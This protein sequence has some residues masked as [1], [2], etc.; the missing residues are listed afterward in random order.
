MQ[1]S[2]PICIAH[3]GASAYFPENTLLSMKKAKEMGALWVEFDVNLTKDNIPVVFHDET[4]ERI[5]HVNQRISD[6]TRD[7]IKD[8]D[9]GSWFNPLY[10]S[11]RIPTLKEVLQ[12]AKLNK[13]HVNIELKPS[14]GREYETVRQTLKVLKETAIN[15]SSEAIFSSFSMKTL[16]I[17]RQYCKDCNIALLFHEWH[18]EWPDYVKKLNPISVNLNEKIITPER[19]QAI[20]QYHL[21]ITAYT[22]NSK[23]R[24]IEL[25]TQGVDGIFSD[26]PEFYPQFASYRAQLD[27]GNH[28]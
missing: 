18:D 25:F 1:Y 6:L 4:L 28:H 11:E 16:V 3:R 24:A 12:L 5:A 26:Y 20:K 8:I 21:K 7:E 17:L 27:K 10:S 9:V 2:F 15:P 14:Q 13:L 22:I 19:L 23:E